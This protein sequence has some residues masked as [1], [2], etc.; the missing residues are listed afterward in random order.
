MMSDWVTLGM[1]IVIGAYLLATDWLSTS[2]W[3]KEKKDERRDE[4]E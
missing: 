2:I 4:P 1:V 3:K